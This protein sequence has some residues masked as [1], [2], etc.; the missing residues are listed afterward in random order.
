[1]TKQLKG[2]IACAGLLAGVLAMLL[3]FG[4]ANG[5]DS[6]KDT[7]TVLITTIV[8][9]VGDVWRGRSDG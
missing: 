1:M 8:Y 4:Y 3:A 7:T 9:L 2:R 5:F 6:V